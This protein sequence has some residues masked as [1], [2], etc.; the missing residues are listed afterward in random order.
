MVKFDAPFFDA[1]NLILGRHNQISHKNLVFY[2]FEKKRHFHDTTGRSY[3]IPVLTSPKQHRASDTADEHRTFY[4]I[5]IATNGT[6]FFPL[7]HQK[8]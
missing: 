5:K 3:P 4:S 6:S 1:S 7:K 2:D 8:K